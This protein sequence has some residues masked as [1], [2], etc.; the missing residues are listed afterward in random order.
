MYVINLLANIVIIC[1]VATG[2][3]GTEELEDVTI[4][5]SVGTESIV[6][7]QFS[8]T[9]FIDAIKEDEECGPSSFSVSKTMF[10][11]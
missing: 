11:A 8:S 7:P 3:L 4:D 1:S 2:K 9:S 10:S 5:T 6:E